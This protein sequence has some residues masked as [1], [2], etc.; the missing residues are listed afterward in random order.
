MFARL[1]YLLFPLFI[2]TIALIQE[3]AVAESTC[4][5]IYSPPAAVEERRIA[6]LF[7]GKI[8]KAAFNNSGSS[9]IML[10]IYHPDAPT[11]SFGNTT[12]EPGE[13]I[14]IGTGNYGSDWGIQMNDGP[15]CNLGKVS[16]W[17]I[18][19]NTNQ[20]Y[21]QIQ[22]ELLG[23]NAESV[24]S[25]LTRDEYFTRGNENYRKRD[26][27]SA[28]KD[29]ESAEKASMPDQSDNGKYLE[30]EIFYNRG[31]TFYRL[32]KYEQAIEEYGKAIQSKEY[33]QFPEAYYNRAEAEMALGQVDKAESD[34]RDLLELYN[35]AANLYTDPS[36]IEELKFSGF[37]DNL[38]FS[39]LDGEIFPIL[40]GVRWRETTGPRDKPSEGQDVQSAL[41]ICR[42]S[43][44]SSGNK[45]KSLLQQS[46]K[47]LLRLKREDL[48]R[49][50]Q[51][52]RCS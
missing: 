35:P 38:D 6:G 8:G 41:S 30:A 31:I 17:T 3:K 11:N 1:K 33:R 46:I 50:V 29:Y 40:T 36:I 25:N 21:F 45:Q 22:V 48:A 16:D 7:D 26:Y 9:T 32:G 18:D 2:F 14:Y 4:S 13:F 42:Q 47:A 51:D 44:R 37:L 24:S 34:Y 28:L 15:I 19:S 5:P 27:E 43:L 39:K 23:F 12:I 52:G 49:K 10:T 20:H